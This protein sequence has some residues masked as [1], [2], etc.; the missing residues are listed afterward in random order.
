VFHSEAYSS[1][2]V[3]KGALGSGFRGR[4]QRVSL[5]NEEGRGETKVQGKEHSR[6]TRI[7]TGEANRN[8]TQLQQGGQQGTATGILKKKGWIVKEDTGLQTVDG[9]GVR[10]SA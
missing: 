5:S 3:A 1:Q 2:A 4:H 7:P 8:Q 10:G 6:I 9:A